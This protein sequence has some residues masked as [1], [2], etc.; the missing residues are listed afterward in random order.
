MGWSVTNFTGLEKLSE[1]IKDAGQCMT[2]MCLIKTADP[3]CFPHNWNYLEMVPS[4]ESLLIFTPILLQRPM[5]CFASKT[6][7]N[8]ICI[9]HNHVGVSFYQLGSG[10]QNSVPISGTNYYLHRDVMC[11]KCDRTGHYYGQCN[12]PY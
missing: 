2:D 6:L 9:T 4:L 11:Y 5:T 7:E 3:Q 12:L 10:K 8:S 1:D